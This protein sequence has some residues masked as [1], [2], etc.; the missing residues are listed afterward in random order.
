MQKKTGA[1][2]AAAVSAEIAGLLDAGIEN[3]SA[4]HFEQA[5]WFYQRVLSLDPNQPEALCNLGAMLSQLGH[6]DQGEAFLKQALV[7]RPHFL[8]ACLALADSHVRRGRLDAAIDLLNR[9]QR[10]FTE[11]GDF[12][13]LLGMCYLQAQ[14]N[15]DAVNALGKAVAIS[16]DNVSYKLQLAA[17]HTHLSNMD[18]AISL[19]ESA[20]NKDPV[21]TNALSVL[22]NIYGRR[23][24]TDKIIEF[25]N[26]LLK[27]KDYK[28]SGFEYYLMSGAYLNKSDIG[29]S[30]KFMLKAIELE[31]NNLDLI[32]SVISLFSTN[33]NFEE[34]EYWL[35]KAEQIAPGNKAFAVERGVMY[36]AQQKN[37]LAETILKAF[38][39]DHITG[40]DGPNRLLYQ[41]YDFLLMALVNQNKIDDMV[42]ICDRAVD[43]F[44]AEAVFCEY[45]SIIHRNKGNLIES[46]EWAQK[47]LDRSP[48]SEDSAF[49]AILFAMHY[50]PNIGPQEIAQATRSMVQKF[51]GAIKPQK[52][53]ANTPA[54]NRKLKIGYVSGDFK[55]HPVA[56]YITPVLQFHNKDRFEVFCYAVNPDA[57]S[58][59]QQLMSYADR[60]RSFNNVSHDRA[61]SM[62]MADGIDILIDLSGHTSLSR[63]QVFARKP[64]PIQ[65]TWIGYF[66][67]TGLP[68]MDYI[69]S[70]KD[71]LPPE[72]EYLYT[73]SPLRLPFSGACYK[74]PD[75]DIGVGPLPALQNGH[76]TFGCF[77]VQRK[78]SD[79]AIALWGEILNRVPNSVLF[80]KAATFGREDVRLSYCERFRAMGIDPKR[81]RFEGTTPMA[82]Y[83]GRYNTV[84]IM[85]DTFPYN[86]ATTCLQ[87]LWMGV[88]QISMRGNML[89][90]RIGDSLMT[91]VGLQEFVALTPEDYV[92]KAVDQAGRL[93]RL[94]EIRARLRPTLINSPMTNP[95]A[96]TEGYEAALRDAWGKWCKE[97]EASSHA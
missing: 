32:K 24:I 45:F 89:V 86:A 75:F 2:Q 90:S 96:F 20:L 44:P 92:A 79:Q 55:N 95:K 87:A 17:A 59:T 9:S 21:N 62:I 68:T 26:Q 57:D 12:W 42:P 14:K 80:F 88:P 63:L 76:I 67:T 85:L 93:D 22:F 58:V 30:I 94:A 31:P 73:E 6:F 46:V 28:L 19:L 78:H 13:G 82:H 37:H 4:S 54:P 74:L 61:A 41:A 1:D 36:V 10:R 40:P 29:E 97:Q 15:K 60:W 77:T 43:L 50:D 56:D 84:D 64:A 83:L 35:E 5:A 91:K 8:E 34:A 71:L 66:N 33:H 51:M 25:G 3:Q 69:I 52:S 48:V 16:P 39:D 81:L 23:G 72:D 38:I 53:H 18:D 27:V 70:D 7:A 65:A 49:G 47:T 11:S